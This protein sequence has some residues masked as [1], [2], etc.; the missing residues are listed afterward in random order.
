[1]YY[2]HDALFPYVTP[3]N[4]VAKYRFFIGKSLKTQIL[5]AFKENKFLITV[6]GETSQE[7]LEILNQ[8]KYLTRA[9]E[10]LEN[11]DCSL[12]IH[13]F[14]FNR[15]DEHI[16][17]AITHSKIEKLFISLHPSNNRENI[18]NATKKSRIELSQ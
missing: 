6:S 16:I 12:F 1:M 8:C 15:D 18:Q 10:R 2:L 3:N 13:G 7:K 17:D 11:A 4:K 14:N 9:L 5:M